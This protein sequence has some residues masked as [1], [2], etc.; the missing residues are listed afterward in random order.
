VNEVVTILEGAEKKLQGERKEIEKGM[1]HQLENFKIDLEQ[2]T[3]DVNKFN[4][5]GIVGTK[6]NVKKET[7]AEIYKVIE[8]LKELGDTLKHIHE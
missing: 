7:Q 4:T 6:I 1:A 2:T 5:T 3:K 8:R